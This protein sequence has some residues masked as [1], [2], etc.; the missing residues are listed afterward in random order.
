VALMK[1]VNPVALPSEIRSRLMTSGTPSE[2]LE[3][4]VGS[5]QVVDALG[6]ILSTEN[7]M[8]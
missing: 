5:G 6:A 7:E 2:A 1:S 4:S 8:L 3:L